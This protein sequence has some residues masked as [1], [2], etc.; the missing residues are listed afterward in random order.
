M[1]Q[2]IDN[3]RD[4]E[5]ASQFAQAMEQHQTACIDEL[6]DR[7][8]EANREWLREHAATANGEDVRRVGRQI[9]HEVIGPVIIKAAASPRPRAEAEA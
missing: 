2:K 6:Y 9:F 8:Q 4:G 7:L 1:S 3:S 5:I